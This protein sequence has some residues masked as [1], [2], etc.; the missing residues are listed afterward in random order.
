VIRAKLAI[1]KA[2]DDYEQEADRISAQVNARPTSTADS[3][4]P[5]HIQRFAGESNGQMDAAPASVDHALAS[6]GTPLARALRQDMEQRFGHDFSRVRVHSD[7]TSG[8]RAQ[9]HGT[10]AFTV[11]HDIVFGRGVFAPATYEGRRL[12]A[13]ELAHVVQADTAIVHSR[14]ASTVSALEREARSVAAAVCGAGN[15]PAIQEAARNPAVPLCDEPEDLGKPTYGNLP[16]DVP[17][18]RGVRGRVRLVSENGV[19]YQK[20][21][22]SKFR[23]DGQY[24]FVVQNGELWATK[25]TARMDVRRGHTE[26]AAGRAPAFS[27]F[28]MG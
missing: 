20:S 27:L 2:G 11:G 4:T 14:P 9:D 22:G 10:R 15:I 21:G 28:E 24:S 7:A 26:A 13:H 23:A 8:S 18:E 25:P 17:D 5:L 12:L 16:R 1:N 6:P 3:G 19:W